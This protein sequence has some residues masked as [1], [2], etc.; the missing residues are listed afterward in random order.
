MKNYPEVVPLKKLGGLVFVPKNF[1]NSITNLSKS[2]FKFEAL[3]IL[4]FEYCFLLIS[5]SRLT[6]VCGFACV[7]S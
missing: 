1:K 3:K 6:Y 5:Q 7:I 4:N 2:I